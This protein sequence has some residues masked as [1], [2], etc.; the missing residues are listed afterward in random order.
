MVDVNERKDFI[1]DFKDDISKLKE[2]IKSCRNI[3]TAIGDESRQHI[4]IS[5]MQNED[6][7]GMRVNDIALVSNLSRPT[8]S[9]HLQILKNAGIID[10]K[11][12]G[13][14]NYY[15]FK[16]NTKSFDMLINMLINAR[17]IT[18]SLSEKRIQND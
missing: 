5:M 7:K 9:H 1:M 12:I 8:V 2:D 16:S 4:I 10:M 6:C 15:Y 13:T 17:T 18:K 14:K 11:R 3:L